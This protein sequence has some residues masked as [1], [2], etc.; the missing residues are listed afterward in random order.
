MQVRNDPGFKY[1]HQDGVDGGPC[2]PFINL[3]VAK[4]RKSRGCETRKEVVEDRHHRPV[5]N[6]E[7]ISP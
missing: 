1:F 5:C 4:H 6:I 2:A 3:G 7:V